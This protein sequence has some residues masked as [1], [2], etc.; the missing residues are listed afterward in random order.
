MTGTPA[1]EGRPDMGAKKA[2]EGKGARAA[3]G[4]EHI[5]EIEALVQ[6]LVEKQHASDERVRALEQIADEQQRVLNR[7]VLEFGIRDAEAWQAKHGDDV[8]TVRDAAIVL[9]VPEQTV[10]YWLD[11]G[12]IKDLSA[13]GPVLI[14]LSAARAHH[15]RR[16][17]R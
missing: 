13:G 16:R 5:R 10:R 7:V 14:S 15:R 11:R 9:G 12:K 2:L 8:V 17:V 4:D 6:D 3:A 1:R